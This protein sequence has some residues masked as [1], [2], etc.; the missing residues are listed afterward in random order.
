MNLKFV[1]I[2]LALLLAGYMGLVRRTTRW[3]TD[4]IENLKFLQDSAEGF[5][6]CAWHGRFLMTTAGWTKMKQRP[7]VLISRS[8]DGNLVALT[9]K[10]LRLGVIRG[11][12]RSKLKD[13]NK[14]GA[15]ALRE[16]I[17]V[18]NQGDCIVMTPDGPRGPRMRMGEGA[19]RLAKISDRPLLAY[20]LSTSNKIVFNSWDKFMLPLP[21]GRGKIV[22]S[23]PIH[24]GKNADDASVEHMRQQFETMMIKASQKADKDIGMKPIQPAAKLDRKHARRQAAQ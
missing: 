10:F 9:A 23:S 1:Q 8:R 4:G 20:G 2:I 14:R 17:E 21:F 19:L 22:L 12:R 18:L 13:K 11:S 24:V 3:Q 16:M 7:H 5:I 15:S 6:V